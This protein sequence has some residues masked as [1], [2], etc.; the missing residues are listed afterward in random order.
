MPGRISMIKTILDEIESGFIV[1]KTISENKTVLHD[2]TIVAVNVPFEDISG[3]AL[4]EFVGKNYSLINGQ[5]MF[6]GIDLLEEYGSLALDKKFRHRER[7]LEDRRVYL[8]IRS[9]VPQ[10]DYLVIIISDITQLRTVEKTSMTEEQ[11]FRAILENCREGVLFFSVDQ[12]VQS[13]GANIAEV[14]GFTEQEL[15]QTSDFTFLR[16]E[17][18]LKLKEAIKH[19]LV[20]PRISSELEFQVI[21]KDGTRLW[22]EGT[23][24][25][26]L[27]AKGVNSIVFKM[28]EITRRKNEEL[29]FYQIATQLL[30]NYPI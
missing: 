13:A 2:F 12:S 26:M 23:L 19:V 7:F 30:N 10:P 27:Q 24:H 14:L 18:R 29:E 9:F 28:K 11:K 4:Q 21:Q 3:F 16:P 22:F 6:L 25:N 20:H 15:K 8:R 5:V 17:D 1:L